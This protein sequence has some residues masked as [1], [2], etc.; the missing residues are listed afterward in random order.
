MLKAYKRL[1]TAYILRESF[2]QLDL[3]LRSLGPQVLR[4]LEGPTSLE[5]LQPYEKFADMIERHW[6][7]IATYCQAENK[8]ALGFV[9]A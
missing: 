7:G 6:D 5:R 9:E 2:D 1:N 4:Q 8:V 3:Q